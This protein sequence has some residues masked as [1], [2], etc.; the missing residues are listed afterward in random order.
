MLPRY[1]TDLTGEAITNI[2]KRRVIARMKQKF[3]EYPEFVSDVSFRDSRRVDITISNILVLL[4]KITGYMNAMIDSIFLSAGG[5]AEF[6]SGDDYFIVVDYLRILSAE[7]MPKLRRYLEFFYNN[8][9]SVKLSDF[10]RVRANMID[11]LEV[12]GELQAVSI[13]DSRAD[14]L[15]DMFNFVE[16]DVSGYLVGGVGGRPRGRPR[17]TPPAPPARPISSYFIPAPA[18][19]PAPPAQVIEGDEVFEI[20]VAPRTRTRR[21]I[22]PSTTTPQID[23]DSWEDMAVPEP[24]MQTTSVSGLPRSRPTIRIGEPVDR[25]YLEAVELQGSYEY[26]IDRQ[27]LYKYWKQLIQEMEGATGV[28][29][30][31]TAIVATYNEKRPALSANPKSSIRD[32]AVRDEEAIGEMV[33]SGK[34]MYYNVYDAGRPTIPNRYA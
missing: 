26:E 4:E 32:E 6:K 27:M 21:F 34:Y 29:S 20:E 10:N 31:W 22:Q 19:A 28:I 3:Q 13:R 23:A 14:N 33:G 8:I 5:R 25:E 24:R 11:L 16:P 12:Y 15:F 9:A 18:P 30:R 2:A 7:E 17:K 1:N